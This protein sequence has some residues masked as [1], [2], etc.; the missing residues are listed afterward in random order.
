[1]R[2]TG[3]SRGGGE[4]EGAVLG[5]E[6]VRHPVVRA[7]AAGQAVGVP[8]V[9]GLDLLAAYEHQPPVHRGAVLA[10]LRDA[11]AVDDAA[12]DDPVGV[13]D[14]AAERPAARHPVAARDPVRPADREDEP[15]GYR[16][17]VGQHLLDHG[18]VEVAGVDP[19]VHADH[20]APA[21]RRVTVGERLDHP[22]LLREGQLGTAPLL[23]HADP[24]HAGSAHQ[25]DRFL[26]EAPAALDL[27]GEFAQSR[28]RGFG[29]GQDRPGGQGFPL[30]LRGGGRGLR[31]GHGKP[32]M[33]ACC[34]F[35]ANG[36]GAVPRMSSRV[37]RR[38]RSLTLGTV[39]PWLSR[40]RA[41]DLT[42]LR[43]VSVSSR[44]SPWLTVKSDF[45]S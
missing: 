5:D 28:C 39:G 26:R 32:P 43:A 41:R 25:S 34:R 44:H 22:G 1:M 23:A 14:A 31:D 37:V 19:G 35:S 20:G 15:G 11:V 30:G 6:V 29:A 40:E 10:R 45:R 27:L 36:S 21:R 24:E 12:A 9:D 3:W 38:P 8:G 33:R 13:R 7:A 17:G 42:R 2:R 16:V 4:V 18:L